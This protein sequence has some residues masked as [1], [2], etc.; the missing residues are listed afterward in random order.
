[1]I[2]EAEPALLD[3]GIERRVER[4]QQVVELGR[5]LRDRNGIA[6]KVHIS[7]NVPSNYKLQL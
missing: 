6:L 3:E 1:M 2:P 4:M 5:L 7:H